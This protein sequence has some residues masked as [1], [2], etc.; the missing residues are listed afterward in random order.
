MD[1]QLLPGIED[2]LGALRG[3]GYELF[4]CSNGSTE[5]IELVLEATGIRA[6]FSGLFSA[7]NH[8]SRRSL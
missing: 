8:K 5:Y 6:F 1:R 3:D 2:V 7:A 4:I